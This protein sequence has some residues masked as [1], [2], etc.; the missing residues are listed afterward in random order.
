M[1]DLLLLIASFYLTVAALAGMLT[2]R[3][4][5]FDYP[6]DDVT[7]GLMWP[8]WVVGLV[9]LAAWGLAVAGVWGIIH[10]SWVVWKV[11]DR[12]RRG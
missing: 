9:F 6:I 8:A 4:E 7:F 3:A 2:R 10:L 11:A 12:V 1:C 5:F